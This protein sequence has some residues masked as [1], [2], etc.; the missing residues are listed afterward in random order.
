M[1]IW[2]EGFAKLFAALKIGQL[3]LKHRQDKTQRQRIVTFVGHPIAETPDEC[4]M[5]GKLLKKNNVALDVINFAHPE[6]VP[7]IEA[8]VEACNN[9]ENSHFLDVPLGINNLFDV[10]FTSPILIPNEDG[11]QP[12]QSMG[13]NAGGAGPAQMNFDQLYQNDPELAE[14]LKISAQEAKE[15]LEKEQAQT[16]DQPMPE[17]PAQPVPAAEPQVEEEEEEDE[18]ALLAKAIALSLEGVPA[19]EAKDEPAKPSEPA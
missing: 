8:L 2:A 15:R 4:K 9:E 14:V 16:A 3:A 17:A 19:E 7:K 18:E 6:N 5:L 1:T 13:G 10:L 11:G 12:S